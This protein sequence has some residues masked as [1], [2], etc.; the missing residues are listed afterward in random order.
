M[1]QRILVPLDGLTRAGAP[2]PCAMSVSIAFGMEEALE[3]RTDFIASTDGVEYKGEKP[4]F[5]KSEI[6]VAGQIW[7]S[8]TRSESIVLQFPQ[9]LFRRAIPDDG[10]EFI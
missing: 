1:Y 5:W 10:V 4:P 3:A 8:Q 7:R 6:S 2:M 9:V